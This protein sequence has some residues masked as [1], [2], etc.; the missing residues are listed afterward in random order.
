MVGGSFTGVTVKT[1]LLLAAPPAP[2]LTVRVM[3]VV[4]P[5]CCGRGV[6]V[7]VRLEAEPPKKIPLSGTRVGLDERPETFREPAAVASS[8]IVK[9]MA[10]VEVFCAMVLALKLAPEM[11]GLALPEP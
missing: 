8:P 9:G 11:V 1:K 3:R 5:V 10:A 2:S 4:A 6:T 7:T